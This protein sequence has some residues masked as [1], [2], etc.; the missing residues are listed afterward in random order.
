MPDAEAV[1][2]A[3]EAAVGD[4]GYLLAYALADQRA[5][6]LQHFAHARPAFRPL[7]ADDDHVAEIVGPA[8]HRGERILLA[9]EAARRAGEL[10]PRHAR[11]LH[12]RPLRRK[13]AL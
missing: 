8:L 5:G 1:R 12:N 6:R 11:D 2:G 4:K 10:Q 9:V 3:R 7:I 13:V